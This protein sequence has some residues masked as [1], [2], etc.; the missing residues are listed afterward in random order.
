ML[1]VGPAWVL[2]QGWD[3]FTAS[4]FF[5]GHIDE[6]RFWRRV[7][8]QDDIR[9]TMHHTLAGT[10]AN[11]LAYYRFD[12][13]TGTTIYDY[14]GA[15][16]N[17]DLQ[18]ATR[19]I[20][21]TAPLGQTSAFLATSSALSH[22]PT[23]AQ[24]EA[25]LTLVSPGDDDNVGLY[26]YGSPSA[27]VAT[28]EAFPAG[29]D[30]RAQLIWGIHER[31]APFMNLTL[32][33]GNLS[34]LRGTDPRVLRREHANAPW[35]DVTNQF[36]LDRTQHTFRRINMPTHVSGSGSTV[37]H[38]AIADR[39]AF[40][41]ELSSTAP[42]QPTPLGNIVP[43]Q[44][45]LTNNSPYRAADIVT[46]IN[47]PAHGLVFLYAEGQGSY[48]TTTHQWTLPSLEG[49][50]TRTINLNGRFLGTTHVSAEIQSA[51]GIEQDA[52]FD[53]GSTTEDDDTQQVLLAQP[54][55]SGAALALSGNGQYVD[56]PGLDTFLS[57]G[58]RAMTLELWVNPHTTNDQQNFIGKHTASGS[59]LIL[60]GFYEGGYH[61]RMRDY[62]FTANAPKQ[63]GWQ[64]LVLEI[65][66]VPTQ[67]ILT[68]FRNGKL[69]HSGSTP[70]AL[71]DL[72]G[73]PWTLGQ[74]WDG[75]T[76]SD[77]LDGDIDEVRFWR[78][79]RSPSSQQTEMHRTLTGSEPELAGYWRFD[80]GAGTTAYDHSGNGHHGVFHGATWSNQS[81]APL[82]QTARDVRTANT[83]AT[84]GQ[85]GAQMQV[86]LTSAAGDD[87]N[88]GIYTVGS[89]TDAPVSSGAFPPWITRRSPLIW[90]VH[91][92]GT[93]AANLV[94]SFASLTNLTLD[95]PRLLKRSDRNQPWQDVTGLYTLD[96]AAKTFTRTN[97]STFSEFTI[98]EGP[99]NLPVEL[100][101]FEVLRTAETILLRWQTASETNN[102]GFYVEQQFVASDASPE[103]AYSDWRDLAFVEGSGTSTKAQAY[104]YRLTD[105]DPGT[106][107][108]RLKQ[109]DFD[110]T[111]S[112]S[113]EVEIHLEVPRL[114]TLEPAYPNPFNPVT[115]LGFTVPTDGNAT[116]RVYDL[117]GRHVATL[118]DGLAKAGHR[119]TQTFD[120]ANLA[121]GTYVYRLTF[122]TQH[123]VGRMIL[124]Q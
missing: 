4:N 42:S 35:E 102:T 13:S 109:I 48:N 7:R 103:A 16:T 75:Q 37:G 46:Q 123:R 24:M 2:G 71:G 44:L 34:G 79:I 59:N 113:E 17:G 26:T 54:V 18:G 72:A 10:E 64:H 1:F 86:T 36:I 106:Y 82:G 91:K 65:I 12:T 100:I 31:G 111:M 118:F 78:G 74:E 85:A 61:V 108:F 11:L 60:L 28:N 38:F 39:I 80:A 119:Y 114:L 94:F 8:S 29:V 51:T 76:T 66:S 62:T 47:W 121:S 21:S 93:I 27:R 32:P 99:S 15:I 6:L 120:A 77:F 105:L 52:V 49:W 73:K 124:L 122:G 57:D 33:F 115:T 58:L 45:T 3:G 90:G 97:V 19:Q 50:E 69:L 20:P 81:T 56:L 70:T 30:Q 89:H 40:D 101:A 41:L 83:P 23:G 112:Y 55:G 92:R 67:T 110:G 14:G 22:G 68:L 9:A 104:Q 53:N 88:L 5:A 96:P 116:L 87:N 95:N 43:L 63:T 25:Q 107:R 98:G 84:V 117:L